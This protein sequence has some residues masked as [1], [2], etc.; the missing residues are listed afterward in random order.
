MVF[1]PAY[2]SHP[3]VAIFL[4]FQKKIIFL[5]IFQKLGLLNQIHTELPQCLTKK[6]KKESRDKTIYCIILQGSSQ[7]VL[8]VLFAW[9]ISGGPSGSCVNIQKCTDVKISKCLELAVLQCQTCVSLTTTDDILSL[10][11]PPSDAPLHQY[12]KYSHAHKFP[13]QRTN[14]NANLIY[15]SNIIDSQ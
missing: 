12:E 11:Q 14:V 10:N 8:V 4:R 1:V 2:G 9:I 7:L 3:K 6:N 15:N 5:F 13:D